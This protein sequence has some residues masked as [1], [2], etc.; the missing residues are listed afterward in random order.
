MNNHLCYNY[1]HFAGYDDSRYT[2]IIIAGTASVILALLTMC[3]LVTVTI[4][5][6]CMIM[7]RKRRKNSGMFSCVLSHFYTQSPPY[8]SEKF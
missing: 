3:V 6:C 7:R 2:I 5:C 8:S 1:I 4:I